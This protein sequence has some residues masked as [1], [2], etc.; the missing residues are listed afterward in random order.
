MAR[1]VREAALATRSARL[2]LPARTK[3]YWRVIEQGLHVG[4]RRRGTG[5]TWIAR[6]RNERGIYREAKSVL[7]TTCR[8]LTA[9]ASSISR[10]RSELRELGGRMSSGLRPGIAPPP[11]PVHRR[12]RHGGLSRGLSPPRRQSLRQHR[13]RDTA[14]YPA[15]ARKRLGGEA[16]HAAARWTGIVGLQNGHGAGVRV[17][18]ARPTLPLSTAR[19]ARPCAGAGRQPI[20]YSLISKPRSIMPGEQAWCHQTTPGA[21]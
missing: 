6:R 18:A 7:P 9:T 17:Q 13:E 15:R 11:R 21:A 16:D 10:R 20:G 12:P 2:R 4:Y 3:P 1:T 8:T 19:M 14:E 5:G